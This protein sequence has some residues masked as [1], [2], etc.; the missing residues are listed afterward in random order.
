MGVALDVGQGQAVVE[1]VVEPALDGH[2][3]C[4]AVSEYLSVQIVRLPPGPTLERLGR[5]MERGG[6]GVC[7]TEAFS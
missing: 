2:C 6:S 5:R 4:V 7:P 3:L 1:L